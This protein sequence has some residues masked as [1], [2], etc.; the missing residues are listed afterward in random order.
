MSLVDPLDSI[1]EEASAPEVPVEGEAQAPQIGER[2]L[3]LFKPC[4][5]DPLSKTGMLASGINGFLA[6]RSDLKPEEVTVGENVAH[7][8]DHLFPGGGMTG[9]PP[10][11]NLA[12]SVLDY[13]AKAKRNPDNGKLVRP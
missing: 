9:W 4:P 7:C 12:L 6:R 11:V 3:E 10:I 1:A 8:V 5:E 13:R 2:V